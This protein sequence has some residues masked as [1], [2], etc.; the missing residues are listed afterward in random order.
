MHANTPKLGAAAFCGGAVT[1]LALL[2]AHPDLAFAARLMIV[3]SGILTGA[4]I[5]YLGYDVRAMLRAIPS[6]ARATMPVAVAVLRALV[7]R[8]PTAAWTVFREFTG[9]PRPFFYLGGLFGCAILFG[10]IQRFDIS[11]DNPIMVLF[12]AASLSLIAS[13]FLVFV[14][15]TTVTSREATRLRWRQRS[16]ELGYPPPT[17]SDYCVGF[18]PFSAIPYADA[19]RLFRDTIVNVLLGIAWLFRTICWSVPIGLV[20]LTYAVW[21]RIHCA[22]R[23]I[24]MV[25]APLGALLAW[26]ALRIAHGD[27]LY[28]MPPFVQLGMVALGGACAALL[29]MINYE[30]VAQRWL[31]TIPIIERR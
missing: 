27:V 20:Q 2:I 4:A 23:T 22:E 8:Y 16:M 9:K 28:A 26:S 7:V 31:K 14:P 10:G 29:G 24:A 17:N 30:F 21:V 18:T 1:M 5:G 15:S 19:L 13:V 6:A 25:D 11:T 12:A 3:L